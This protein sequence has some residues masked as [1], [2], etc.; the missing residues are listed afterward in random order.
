MLHTAISA[1]FLPPKLLEGSEESG[2][3]AP[4]QVRAPAPIFIIRPGGIVLSD[5]Q[6]IVLT[7]LD[8]FYLWGPLHPNRK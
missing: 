7:N 8:Y 2:P 6:Q 4:V 3:Q 1:A 5:I